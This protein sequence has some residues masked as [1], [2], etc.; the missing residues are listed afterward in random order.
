MK[1]QKIINLFDNTPNQSSKFKTKN[2]V[3]IND[4]S[5]GLCNTGN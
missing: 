3:D 2:W 5:Y 4:E 1:Y